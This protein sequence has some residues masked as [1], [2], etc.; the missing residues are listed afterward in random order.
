MKKTLLLAAAL[1]CS[2]AVAQE[3][4]IWAC[5]Q[6]AGTLLNWEGSSW[7]N[8]GLIGVPLLLTLDG[9][10]S[11]YKKND[12]VTRLTCSTAGYGLSCLN[13][14]KTTHILIDLNSGRLGMSSLYGAVMAAWK[15]NYKDTINAEAFNCTK[16]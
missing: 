16:F 12:R 10:N 11:S 7:R 6:I 3:K 15:E 13:R 2:G 1:V 14:N 5:Q 8:V 9:E 4:E